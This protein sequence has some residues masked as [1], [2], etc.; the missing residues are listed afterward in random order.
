MNEGK[1]AG[2]GRTPF[3]GLDEPFRED[4]CDD[5]T[6]ALVL[7]SSEDSVTVDFFRLMEKP[8]FF[9]LVDF[10]GGSL[11]GTGAA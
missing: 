7:G 9:F 5:V 8:N 6:L 1:G 10:E 3:R 2:A 4:L 11:T